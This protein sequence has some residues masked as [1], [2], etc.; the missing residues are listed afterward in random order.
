MDCGFCYA[1]HSSYAI[2][3]G[4]VYFYTRTGPFM[5]YPIF[6]EWWLDIDSVQRFRRNYQVCSTH[7]DG[8]LKLP[9]AKGRWRIIT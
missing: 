1:V 7:M 6:A 8:V 9:R 4:L 2:A 5:H 3:R